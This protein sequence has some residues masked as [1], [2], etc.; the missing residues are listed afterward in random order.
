MNLRKMI[1]KGY[2]PDPAAVVP[3]EAPK[4]QKKPAKKKKPVKKED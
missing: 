2:M 4:A 1:K 3:E